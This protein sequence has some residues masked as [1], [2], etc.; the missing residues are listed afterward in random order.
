M[1]PLSS[2]PQLCSYGQAPCEQPAS[3]QQQ[4]SWQSER[5]QKLLQQLPIRRPR[6]QQL[7]SPALLPARQQSCQNGCSGCAA[8]RKGYRCIRCNGRAES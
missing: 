7:P 5:L 3:S 8:A 2:S 4:T 1:M 6:L